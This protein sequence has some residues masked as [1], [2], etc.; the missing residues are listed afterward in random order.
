MLG[1]IH[2]WWRDLK[3]EPVAQAAPKVPVAAG[4]QGGAR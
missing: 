1:Y 3:P 2:C 4:M